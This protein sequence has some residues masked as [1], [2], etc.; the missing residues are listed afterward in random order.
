MLSILLTL[1]LLFIIISLYAEIIGAAFTFIIAVGVLGLFHILTPAEILSG[2]ANEQVAVIIMLLLLGEII[3]GTAIIERTFDTIYN[4]NKPYRGFMFRIMST[5]AFFSAFLNN[6][7]LVAVMMPYVNS[8]GKKNNVSSSK[9]LIPLS[10]A[11]ILGGSTTLIGTSTN[12]IVNGMVKDQTLFPNFNGLHLFE[13]AFVGLPMLIIGFAYILFI[14]YK[15]LPSKKS[16]VENLINNRNYIVE[17][18][19]RPKSKLIGKTIEEANLRN[20]EGLYLVEIVRGNIAIP[21]VSPKEVL[22]ENDLLYFAGETET[23]AKLYESR[24][25]ALFPEVLPTT[26]PTKPPI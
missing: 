1:L 24:T 6:T 17:A 14:G 18:I 2:F 4:H 25:I 13:F 5:T 11:A 26:A 10:Y 8:W 15:L 21:A 23:S 22:M 9:L 19:I 12:L 20:L 16:D 7:P 3:R